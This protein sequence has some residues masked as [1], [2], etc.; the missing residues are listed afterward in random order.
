M[1]DGTA[2]ASLWILVAALF[3]LQQEL[4]SACPQAL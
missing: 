1:G 4:F 2:G 3:L